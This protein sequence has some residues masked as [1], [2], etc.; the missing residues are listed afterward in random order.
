MVSLLADLADPDLVDQSAQPDRPEVVGI[1]AGQKHPQRRVEGD[2]EN[3]RH[4]H[5]QGLGVSQG[6]EQTS[7]FGLEGE[8]REERDADDEQ[9]EEAGRG[10]LADCLLDKGL[11][12]AR[13]AHPLPLL[14]LFVGLLD[15]HDG[16]VAEGPDGDGDTA[17]GH[18]I[19]GQTHPLEGDEGDQHRERNRNDRD[20]RARDVPEEE[21]NH[22][23]ER[24]D[25][26]ED[27][28]PQVVHRAVDELR[29]VV[30]DDDLHTLG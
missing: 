28:S 16:G 25:D 4:H 10:H 9:G 21:Q 19:G 30:A 24:Q 29:A 17:K 2:G 18:D 26:L 7:L 14:E 15:D 22:K 1:D 27:R 8:H 6:P 3:R 23:A 13:P 20:G 11:V 5:G 12:V